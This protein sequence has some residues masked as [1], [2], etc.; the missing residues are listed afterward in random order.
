MN[1][2]DVILVPWSLQSVGKG[3]GVGERTEQDIVRC[4]LSAIKMTSATLGQETS[5][6]VGVGLL[7]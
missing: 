7:L 2:T 3:W 5:W 4:W 1:E 6:C